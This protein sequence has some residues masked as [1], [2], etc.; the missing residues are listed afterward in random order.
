MKHNV[1]YWMWRLS[2][3]LLNDYPSIQITD[4]RMMPYFS[5][6]NIVTGQVNTKRSVRSQANNRA[7]IRLTGK[8]GNRNWN[9]Y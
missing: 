1:I 7:Q 6:D 4:Y 5:P 3:I 9:N 8:A 2:F